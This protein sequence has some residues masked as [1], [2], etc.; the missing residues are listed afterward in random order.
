V[1]DVHQG[2][3]RGL[4]VQITDI[5]ERYRLSAALAEQ[6]ELLRV[7]LQSIGDAVITSDAKGFITWLNPVAERMTGWLS[8]EAQGRPLTQVFHIV[9]EETRLP[10]ENPV[11]RCLAAERVVGLANQTVL[12]SRDG[13]EYGIEDSASPIRDQRG[14]VLGVVLVF[15]DVSQQRRMAGE[16]THR[17]THDEL[18]DLPNRT[19]FEI[20]LLRLLHESHQH[21][22]EHSMLYLDLD[23][24]KLV[25][26]ACGHAAGDQ[27]LMQ[28]SKLFAKAVR[29]RDTLARLGGDEFGILLEHCT[30]TEAQVVGQKICDLMEDFRFIHDNRRFRIGASIGLVPVDHRWSSTAA[31]HQAAD[32][33]CYAAKEAGRNRI[34]TWFDTDIAIRERS[35]EAHWATRIESALD[36]DGMVLFAQ[37]IAPLTGDV[38]GLHAEVLVRMKNEDGTL[39]SAGAFLP[40]AERFS[41]VSRLDRWVLR[42][43]ISWLSI[44]ARLSSIASL[45]V[46]LSGQSV[47]D[48]AFHA[49]A[50]KVLT[51]A[52]PEI[53]SKICLEITE[54]V[55]IT[56][57]AD[58]TLFIQQVRSAGVRVALDDF[59]AGASTFGYLKS[60]P[61]DYLKIDG[62]FVRDLVTDPLD[63]AAVRC[64]ADVARLV[65]VQT[66][67]EFVESAEILS[68]IKEIGIDFAQGFFLHRPQPIEYLLNPQPTDAATLP[69][70][71]GLV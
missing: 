32:A 27:L 53:R 43:V 41:L 19:A 61:V 21:R 42:N 7:T 23:Q 37:R 45:N 3:V 15:H 35:S 10:T 9:N 69:K 1:P 48:R 57:M 63:E 26:D 60:L 5:S 66:V 40:A 24:F 51:E 59:G 29:G 62:Q 58:A 2:K 46:N 52:G 13:T 6:H 17:A 4:L 71:Q 16:M 44:P 55:A 38:G 25:N 56:N 8:I 39:T 22:S 54:T 14:D 31:I 47:G 33:S 12:I 70:G 20:R 64:F 11:A 18:T 67:A 50:N 49:W 68:R 65:G 28:V 30:V 34:H 36:D